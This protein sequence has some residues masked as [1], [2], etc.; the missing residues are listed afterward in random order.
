MGLEKTA[1]V[2]TEASGWDTCFHQE[3]E[4]GW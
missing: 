4:E 3:K 2:V 1:F